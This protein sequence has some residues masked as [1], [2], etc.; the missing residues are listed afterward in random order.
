MRCLTS[1]DPNAPFYEAGKRGYF[2]A[3]ADGTIPEQ[4]FH[5]PGKMFGLWFPPLRVM[6]NIWLEDLHGRK[7]RF[8]RF[9]THMV[10]RKM[11]FTCGEKTVEVEVL[12]DKDA[13]IFFFSIQ[14]SFPFCFG[15]RFDET[16]V[17]GSEKLGWQSYVPDLTVIEGGHE[18]KCKNIPRVY[19][20]ISNSRMVSVDMDT[21]MVEVKPPSTVIA[22]GEDFP[23]NLLERFENAK[24]KKRTYYEFMNPEIGQDDSV[25]WSKNMLLDMYLE[26]EAGRGI[27]A[28]HPEFPW[29]F[30]VD[31]F[32]TGLALL[33]ARMYEHL[34]DTLLT[35]MEYA[36]D[37]FI[38][39]EI[40]SN[41]VNQGSKRPIETFMFVNISI[42]YVEASGN[43]EFLK[44]HY[45]VMKRMFFLNMPRKG[46]PS[47][48][49]MVELS[50]ME[51]EDV[52]TLDTV[53]A[54][55]AAAHALKQGARMMGKKEDERTFEDVEKHVLLDLREWYD[56]EN[57]VFFDVIRKGKGRFLGTFIQMFPLFFNMVDRDTAV[58]VLESLKKLG[59]VVKEG[60][61]HSMLDSGINGF[62]SGKADKIWWVANAILK[63][64]C[65]QYNLMCP[66][67]LEEL[68]IRDLYNGM[69]G[70]IPEIV[71]E[72][73]GCFAQAWS[74][75]FVLI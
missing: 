36:N 38:P 40:V 22:I 3:R 29:W 56:E 2:L 23:G 39:H 54:V 51:T 64:S 30:G 37:Q 9:E 52:V 5:I 66:E 4:G 69:P 63:K 35:L 18:F 60:L 71:G 55:Y 26:T 34:G 21:L 31:T 28:G 68:Y 11:V 19:R 42:R 72:K 8:S 16:P 10:G 50:F 24:E 12:F 53:C 49:G 6:R 13:P 58:K 32:F 57:G 67:F 46:Y 48:P 1:D 20:I 45:D 70:A 7:L 59:L 43:M 27:V 25:F 41:G 62:Y 14:T 65:M 74:T 61:K 44:L 75:L 15:M 47:G 17:W 73:A 33:K